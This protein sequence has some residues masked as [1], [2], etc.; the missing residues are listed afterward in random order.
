LLIQN[1]RDKIC[2]EA[3]KIAL[4]GGDTIRTIGAPNRRSILLTSI[5]VILAGFFVFAWQHE[6]RPRPSPQAAREMSPRPEPRA[7][8]AEEEG[9]AASLWEIHREVTPSAVAMSFAGIVYETETHDSRQLEQKLEP[10]ARF[11]GDA[12]RRVGGLAVPA[13][14]LKVHGQYLEAMVLYRKASDEMLAFTKDG[15][16]QHLI[17]AQGMGLTASEDILRAGEVL[18]PGQ[19]KPH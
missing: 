3:D 6:L 15:R 8:T 11:F 9:Y 18:W 12:E 4:R 2:Q 1:L 14:L 13:S 19:Y 5:V 7:L 10:I 16:R 17:D